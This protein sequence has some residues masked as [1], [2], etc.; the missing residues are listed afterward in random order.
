VT[1]DTAIS[2]EIKYAL[3][4]WASSKNAIAS[5]WLFGSRAKGIH[6]P[7]SDYDLAIE[8]MP[9][10]GDHDWA[11]GDYVFMHDEWKGDLREIVKADIS[12]VAFRDDLERPFDP[13]DHGQKLWPQE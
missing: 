11:L 5:L 10:K 4:E 9:K 3:R 12:L 1:V 6:R 8:L 2:E 13:R 7:S